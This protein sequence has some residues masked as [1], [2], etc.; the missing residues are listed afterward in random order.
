[1]QKVRLE[2][3]GVASGDSPHRSRVMNK[4][5]KPMGQVYAWVTQAWSMSIMQSAIES[6]VSPLY[7]QPSK[8]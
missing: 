1:M 7:N 2:V 4:E 3:Q 8:H 5:H 6:T